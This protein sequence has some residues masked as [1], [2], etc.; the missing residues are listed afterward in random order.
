MFLNK[1]LLIKEEEG[2]DTPQNMKVPVP[3]ARNLKD[4]KKP[5]WNFIRR[6]YTPNMNRKNDDSLYNKL[7]VSTVQIPSQHQ[8]TNHESNYLNIPNLQ[9]K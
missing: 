2:I 6:T 1:Q 8:V 9:S 3:S 5:K 4:D 7:T